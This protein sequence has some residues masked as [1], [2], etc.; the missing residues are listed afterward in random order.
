VRS[1]HFLKSLISSQSRN[2][3]QHGQLQTHLY[4]N[5]QW[6]ELWKTLTEFAERFDLSTIQLNV[7]LPA[8]GEEYHAS[9]KRLAQPDES[10]LWHSEIPLIAHDIN[11]G[12]LRIAGVCANGS[13]CIWMSDLIAGLKPFESQLLDLLEEDFPATNW[14][15]YEES[16]VGS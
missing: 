7:H 13:V 4:G 8:H 16:L 2:G 14:T 5:G 6:E 11:V 1:K 15:S 3:S 12:R 9:W 10:E